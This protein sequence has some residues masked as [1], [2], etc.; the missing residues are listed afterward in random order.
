[1]GSHVH[2]TASATR[3]A[4]GEKIPNRYK[5]KTYTVIQ[6]VSNRMLLKELYSWVHTNDVVALKQVA[7][8]VGQIVRIKSS[9][10]KYA[11]STK[12][13]TKAYKN[14]S[15]T[16]QQVGQND[17]LIKELYSQVKKDDIQ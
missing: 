9:A 3:Y 5:N 12:T 15:Y 2:L 1:K 8:K 7:F 14:K 13:I 10:K 17:V 6:R 4:T 11:R 16:I